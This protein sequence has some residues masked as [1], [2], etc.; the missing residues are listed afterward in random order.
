M[1]ISHST[2]A[3]CKSGTNLVLKLFTEIAYLLKVRLSSALY[4]FI[5]HPPFFISVGVA[6]WCYSEHSSVEK[7]NHDYKI[8]CPVLYG[9]I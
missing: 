5:P 6:L 2:D 9:V 8:L 1:Y 7:E 4:G 3:F